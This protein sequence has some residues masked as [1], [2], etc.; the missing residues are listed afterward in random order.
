MS[1]AAHEIEAV[2]VGQAKRPVGLDRE[3][4][5]RQQAVRAHQPRTHI[6]V[7]PADGRIVSSLLPSW[8]RM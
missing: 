1:E 7:A 8:L 5:G 2:D 4:R 6:Q 3:V